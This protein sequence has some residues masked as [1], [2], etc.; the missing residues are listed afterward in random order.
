MGLGLQKIHPSDRRQHDCNRANGLAYSRRAFGFKLLLTFHKD[1]TG[2]RQRGVTVERN[3]D[4]VRVVVARRIELPRPGRARHASRHPSPGG[5]GV[6]CTVA[7]TV[8]APRKG[9]RT[10][11]TSTAATPRRWP[12]RAVGCVRPLIC[13]AN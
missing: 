2:H 13:S 6:E 4:V 5:A 3:Q 11:T 10:A 8:V 1:W 7:Q 9:A 12:P